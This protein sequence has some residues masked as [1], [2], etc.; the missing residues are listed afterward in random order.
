MLYKLNICISA[1]TKRLG[2]VE[3]L[4][5]RSTAAVPFSERD[6][7]PELDVGGRSS[8]SDGVDDSGGESSDADEQELLRDQAKATACLQVS[9]A[10]EWFIRSRRRRR[11]LLSDAPRLYAEHKESLQRPALKKPRVIPVNPPQLP[12]Y[13]PLDHIL[14]SDTLWELNTI[15]TD[16]FHYEFPN[17]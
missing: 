7:Q 1:W 17:Q 9:E 5:R 4:R 15:P 3:R 10:R 2:E 14:N 11:G 8:G 16:G 6:E 12:T 13:H